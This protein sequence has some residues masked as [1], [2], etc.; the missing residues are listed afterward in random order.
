MK[1]MR[2]DPLA[3]PATVLEMP[4]TSLTRIGSAI[5]HPTGDLS[6]QKNVGGSCAG[7]HFYRKK[8]G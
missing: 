8:L 3:D 5:H 6:A 2:L 7:V 1:T 4:G